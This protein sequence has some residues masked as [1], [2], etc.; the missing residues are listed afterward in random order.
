MNHLFKI[1]TKTNIKNHMSNFY[2]FSIMAL[3]KIGVF[4]EK[5]VEIIGI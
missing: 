2:I 4:I 5:S 3:R 1:K